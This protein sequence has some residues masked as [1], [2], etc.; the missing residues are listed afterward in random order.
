MVNFTSTLNVSNV[1]GMVEFLQYI[2]AR[3]NS[4]FGYGLLGAT[5]AIVFLSLKLYPTER[6][7]VYASFL[8][9][10]MGIFE[11]ILGLI[12]PIVVALPTISLLIS[13]F[14]LRKEE[15]F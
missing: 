14:A 15:V 3:S 2:N 4:L 1:T 9:V 8:T 10:I 11:S 13:V 5:F 12:N 7:F 6:A